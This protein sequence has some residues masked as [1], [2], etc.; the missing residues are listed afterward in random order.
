MSRIADYASSML[1][2]AAAA[3][4]SLCC[5]LPIA[6]VLSGLG[7]GAFMMTTMKYRYIF[8]PVGVLGVAASYAMYFRAR[9]QCRTLTCKMVG[10]RLNLAMLIVTTMIVVAALLLDFFPAATADILQQAVSRN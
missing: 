1:S 2:A 3:V 9:R 5:I 10:G 7:T 6:V 4:S 8:L